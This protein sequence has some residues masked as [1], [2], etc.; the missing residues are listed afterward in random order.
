MIRIHFDRCNGH[1]VHR[2]SGQGAVA[3]PGCTRS[4]KQVDIDLEK[5]KQLLP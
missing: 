5:E 3:P 4:V 2:L 1:D